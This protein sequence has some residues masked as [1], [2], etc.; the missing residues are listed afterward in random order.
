MPDAAALTPI[1]RLAS[2]VREFAITVAL[3]FLVLRA[4]LHTLQYRAILLEESPSCPESLLCRVARD[5]SCLAPLE[6]LKITAVCALLVFLGMEAAMRIAGFVGRSVPCH[7]PVDD[8]ERGEGIWVD[9]KVE[10]QARPYET[11]PGQGKIID[12]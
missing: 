10:R 7:S 12:T 8:V 5:L 1:A 2:I 11:M 4:I 6:V 9:A 3:S